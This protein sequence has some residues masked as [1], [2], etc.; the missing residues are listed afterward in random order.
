[1]NP[2]FLWV[3]VGA[4]AGGFVNGLTGFGTAM[5]ALVFWLQVL[6]PTTAASLA[7]ICSVIGQVQAL[8]T[9]WHAINW[10]RVLPFLV[11]GVAGIPVGTYLLALID[12]ATFKFWV[13]AF[14]TTYCAVMLVN[15]SRLVLDLGSFFDGA[16]GFIGGVLGALAGLSGAVPTLWAGLRGWDK[17]ERRA[18]FQAFNLTILSITVVA[19]AAAGLLTRSVGYALLLAVPG[20]VIGSFLGQRLYRSLDERRFDQLVLGILLIAGILLMFAARGARG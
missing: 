12:I 14:V 2:E 15:R 16:I 18:V 10:K 4:L 3:T 19:H 20:T 6:Q 1:M 8:P 7:A 11:G 5:S 17:D 13:G 9:V